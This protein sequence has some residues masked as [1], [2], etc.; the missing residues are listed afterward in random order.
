MGVAWNDIDTALVDLFTAEMGAASDYTT[1]KVRTLKATIVR[2]V[3]DWEGWQLPAIVITGLR[4]EREAGPHGGGE[5]HFTKQMPYLILAIAEGD[6]VSAVRDAKELEKR[7]EAVLRLNPINVT[8]DDGEQTQRFSVGR[9]D[10]D[11]FR[12]SS[13]QDRRFC[14]AGIRIDVHSTI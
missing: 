8:G 6:E 12:K 3:G 5:R 9:T 7:A 4:V 10:L 1:L 13:T 11:L 14:V 2:N